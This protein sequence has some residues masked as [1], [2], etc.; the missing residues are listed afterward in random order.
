MDNTSWT[1]SIA[2]RA[3]AI[4]VVCCTVNSGLNVSPVV[5]GVGFT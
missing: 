5:T 1:Y 2:K 3:A 4:N